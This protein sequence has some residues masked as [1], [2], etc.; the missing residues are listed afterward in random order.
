MT[1][2][3]ILAAGLGTRLRP[4]TDHLPKPMVTV[5]D[6]PVLQHS[7]ELCR[8]HGINQIAINLSH[9]P[10]VITDYFG[11]GSSFGVQLQ[12]SMETELQGTAGALRPFLSFFDQT[13]VVIYGDVLSHTDLSRMLAFHQ[14][15]GGVAT[16]GLYRVPNPQ[17][18]GL[19]DLDSE[20]RVTRFVE[21]PPIDEVFT[22]LANA[23]I[24][25]LEP[26]VLDFVGSGFSDFGKDV[27]PALLEQAREMYGYPISEYLIDIGSLEKLEQARRQF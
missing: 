7:I 8:Q 4:L 15:K 5:Q 14:E 26:E 1:K 17:E 3:M 12:F 19:V 2:A 16:I 27:F 9:L 6:K 13:F 11:D 20:G 23:G 22:D 10:D 21:K 18:C 24:Y 25:V